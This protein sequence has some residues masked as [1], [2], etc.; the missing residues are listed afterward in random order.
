M[1]DEPLKAS[2]ARCAGIPVGWLWQHRPAALRSF[3]ELRRFTVNASVVF[4]AAVLVFITA[5]ATFE[6]TIIIDPVSVPKS[7]E[8]QGYAGAA[9]SRKLIDLVGRIE[10]E[11]KTSK[12]KERF[13]I[14]SRFAEASAIRLPSSS[15]SIQS[16]VTLLRN[17]FGV[18]GNRISGEIT[19]KP[20]EPSTFVLTLHFVRSGKRSFR[21]KESA[22]LDNLFELSARDVVREFDGVVLASYLYNKRTAPPRGAALTEVDELLDEL[23]RTADR[24]TMPWVLNLR[25]LRL[26]DQGKHAEAQLLFERAVR[27][28][29]MFAPGYV[30]MGIALA[31]GLLPGGR[32]AAAAIDFYWEAVRYQPDYATAYYDWGLVLQREKAFDGAIAKFRKATEIDATYAPAYRSLAISLRGRGE[33]AKRRRDYEEAIANHRLAIELDREQAASNYTSWGLTLENRADVFGDKS[34]YDEA[35]AKF[36]MATRL[37]AKDALAYRSWAT[38]LARQGRAAE[39]LEKGREAEAVER[40]AVASSD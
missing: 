34:D 38:A 6:D 33:A 13:G 22:N 15:L 31:D 37:N 23:S 4:F 8:E 28:N 35:I 25:G 16:I 12:A 39:A 40:S 3:E 9:I 20:A 1:P 11:S 17:A 36:E 29:P 27:L 24:K 32:N 30:N 21:A 18:T 7:L 10:E 26:R 19:T 2:D 14:D 5:Q